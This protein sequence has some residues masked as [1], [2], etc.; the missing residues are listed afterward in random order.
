MQIVATVGCKRTFDCGA[1]E[2]AARRVFIPRRPRLARIF[3]EAAGSDLGRV[4]SGV[5]G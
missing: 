2:A 5:V 1:Y 3:R 4:L